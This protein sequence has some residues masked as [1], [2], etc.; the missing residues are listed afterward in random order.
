MKNSARRTTKSKA[1][2]A[3]VRSDKAETPEE[4]QLKAELHAAGCDT[5]EELDAWCAFNTQL[6]ADGPDAAP[7]TRSATRRLHAK[8]TAS[9]RR[10]WKVGLILDHK[11]QRPTRC[12][13]NVMHVLAQHPAWAGVLAYDEFA[14]SIVARRVP[15]TRKH[16]RP[17]EQAPGDWTDADTVRSA[18]WFAKFV[19]FEPTV[20][21][22]DDAVAAIAMRTRTHAVRE[23]LGRLQWDRRARLDTMLASYFGARDDRYVR[24]VGPKWMISA[25]ARVMRPGC[26]ADH[27][28]ILEGL[29]GLR[30]STGLEAL[31]DDPQWF[32]DT[33][34]AIGD[35]D[36]YQAL[37]R[38]W[39]IELA[40]LDALRG[41]EAS[42]V[43]KFMSARADSFRPPY[44]RHTQRFPRQCVFAGTTNEDAY[45]LDATGNRR[46]WPVA[47]GD[48]DVDAIR[49]DRDQ[50]WAEA[51]VRFGRGEAWHLTDPEAIQLALDAQAEREAPDD[52][53]PLVAKYLEVHARDGITTGETLTKAIEVAPERITRALS[54]RAGHVLRKLGYLPQQ[55]RIPG[56]P[57][58]ARRYY[59]SASLSQLSQPQVRRTKKRSSSGAKK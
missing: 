45:L 3:A 13:A 21:M 40:E 24:T 43:K 1:V 36:S 53:I 29:Q 22:V 8:K 26:Q 58:R 14:A 5:A 28:L 52:W 34:I 55:D 16:D 59:P 27:M 42:V 18:A 48:V 15:P 25:V 38:R 49:R 2:R 35:K 30:K 7:E 19:G 6:D 50:L 47:C 44:G 31:C 39:I 37:Q 51:L 54:T 33:I 56:T 12:L 11:R 10:F 41:R 20:R 17:P 23:Y 57:T 32:T 4:L 9:T 46:Y